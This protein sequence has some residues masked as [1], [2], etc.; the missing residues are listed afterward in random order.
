MKVFWR[1]VGIVLW[2]SL[3]VSV[4]SAH[5][6]LIKADPAPNSAVGRA[7]SQ[8]QLWFDESIEP[9]FSQ[10]QVLDARQQHGEAGALQLA[11]GDNKSIII[12]LKP[13]SDGTHTVVWRVLSATDGHIT[14]GV[15]AFSVGSVAG[16]ITAPVDTGQLGG[17]SELTPFSAT[18]RWLSLLALLALVGGFFFKPFLL[19]RSLDATNTR[20][21]VEAVA[22]THWLQL[23]ALAFI[24]LLV[25][26]L[27]E[28]VAQVNLVTSQ[29]SIDATANV[30]INTRFGV[31][32]LLRMAFL[33]V[34]ALF[35]YVVPRWRKMGTLPFVVMGLGVAGLYTRSLSSHA[36]ANGNVS[37]GVLSDWLHLVA[38]SLW[39]GGLFYFAFLMPFI[40]QALDRNVRGAWISNL[41]RQFS[42]VGLGATLVILVTGTINS[43]QQ[44]PALDVLTTRVMP[45]LQSLVSSPY[46]NTLLLKV[47][48]FIVMV[49]FGAL[50][51]LILSPRFRRAITQP[52]QNARLF[53]RFRLTVG[54]EVLL[55]IS[56]IFLAGMLTLTVPP[57]SEPTQTAP[58]LVQQPPRAV[59]LLGNPAPDVHVQLEI[60]PKPDDP[61]LLDARVTDAQGNL[62]SNVQRVIFNF[63]YL[64]QDAGTQ[65][66]IA[67]PREDGH[68]VVEGNQFPLDGMWRIRVTV[69]RQGVEDV[70]VEFPYLMVRQPRDL[71][72][73]GNA[74]LTL[75]QAQTAM[76]A[77]TTLRSRQELN[78]GANGL[79]VSLYDYAAPNKTRFRIEGQ[80]ESIAIGEKQYYQDNAGAWSERARVEPF[81][82]P[83]FD[84]VTT[85]QRIRLGRADTLAGTPTQ[86][87]L[88]DTPN[89]SGDELIHY[90]YWLAQDDKRLLQL[91]MVTSSHYMMQY[92]N[93]FNA[94]DVV[95]DAP[96][97]VVVVPTPAPVA[98]TS[99]PLSTLVNVTRPRGIITGDLEG[100]GAL[101]MVVGGVVVLLVGGGAKR[102]R[103]VRFVT[104][105]IGAV[106]VA[107]GILLFIDAVNAT[108]ALATNAPVNPVRASGGQ[109][110]YTQNCQA[111]HGEKGH[112]DGP[113]GASLPVKP[114]DLTTHVLL[115]D[116]QYLHAVILNGRGYMPAFGNRLSQDQILDVIAYIRQMAIQAR[117][118]PNAPARG[119]TPQP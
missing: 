118:Q 52:E 69:R 60:G 101:V 50:N 73:V 119:F 41:V 97:N 82:F 89:T 11:P 36:A 93:D 27:A 5:A 117:Q 113:G 39:V 79:A 58:V 99:S 109:Q 40:W 107:V 81:T 76:N 4:A 70:A 19:D 84:F 63:M 68:Y 103:N 54:G 51:F 104:L 17:A 88:F 6:K 112:G 85:A 100:D 92:Y 20:D 64:D 33:A 106:S 66:V 37:L 102:T 55:G 35:I 25:G 72:E 24:L 47:A 49:G 46:D 10:A 53:T 71:N 87:V 116:E 94:P 43:I 86:I 13:L 8:V 65:N 108:T 83:N 15:Y 105:G 74:R 14:S 48:L 91:A 32:W 42:L 16:P 95:I 22:Q 38:V 62:I 110:I 23:T 98:D 30:L 56:A 78:D 44:I 77:L 29:V 45:S 12:P 67:E 7:P 90:A 1:V 115:H 80:G 21:A 9:S 31:L 96:Q 2:L 57:R 26:N 18:A 61:S 34:C 111:C 28:L 114:F 75:T 59:S 3:T